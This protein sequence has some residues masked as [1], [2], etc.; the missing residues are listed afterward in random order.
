MR[1][2]VIFAMMPLLA[3]GA[4][5][6]L[7]VSVQ[8][9]VRV[10]DSDA[11]AIVLQIDSPRPAIESVSGTPYSRISLDNAMPPALEG[12]PD[13]PVYTGML[14]IPA[15]AIYS[16]SYQLFDPIR[17][18]DVKPMPVED[19]SKALQP[20]P[21]YYE[22]GEYPS[23]QVRA[24]SDA[25]I[26]DYRV[27][28]LQV[29]PFSWDPAQNTLTHY[30]SIRVSI[31]L[32]YPPADSGPQPY[33]TDSAAFRQLYEARILN[34]AKLRDPLSP[35]Q[36]PRVLI[37]HGD[38]NDPTFLAKLSEFATWKRQKGFEVSVAS[39]AVAGTSSTAIKSYIQAL[40]D[41]PNTRPD[42]IILIGDISGSFA[43][44]TCYETDSGYNGAGDY[45][46]TYLSGNDMLGDAFIGRMSAE[47]LSQLITLFSKVYTYEKNVNTTPP[48]SGWLNRMLII[49]DP[50][51]SGVSCVYTGHFI[52]NI[53]QQAH[54]EYEFIE[55]Y[56]D[57][58]VSTINSGI[59]QGVGFFAYRGYY[60]VSGWS[61]S[62]SLMNSVRLPHSVI[63]TCGTGPYEGESLSE[64]FIRMGTESV[65]AGAATCIGMSTSHTHTLFNNALTAGIM[66]G[67]MTHRMRTMGEALL[68]GRIYLHNVY[69]AALPDRVKAHAH[70][71]NL[72]GDPT[73]EA[74]VGI[75]T[76]LS[77]N[78]PASIPAGTS[79]LETVI[80]D[81]TGTPMQAVCVTA[82]SP[83]QGL[84]VAKTFTNSDGIA[85]L[86]L[87][88]T[89]EQSILITASGHD[90]KPLQSSISINPAGSLVYTAHQIM[91]NGSS[92]SSGNA[93]GIAG[94]GE[95]IALSVSLLNSTAS[96]LN[97]ISA[98]L[99]ID[100]PNL[101]ILVNSMPYPDMAAGF[102][103]SGSTPFLIHI[104]SGIAP[105]QEV[106]CVLTI[107]ASNSQSFQ[108]VFYLSVRNARLDVAE[109]LVTDGADGILDA[110]ETCALDLQVINSGACFVSNIQAELRSLDNLVVVT[111]S[112]S[113]FGN[114][115]AGSQ[116]IS[117]DGF[118]LR[119]KG[120][121]VPGM[122]VPMRLRLFNFN[123]FEQICLF[124]I[125]VGSVS[126]NTPLGPDAYGYL[127]Y[128]DTDTAFADCPVYD[129]VEIVPSLGGPG[130]L[131][132]GLAD[133]G[134]G[135]AEG[136]TASAHP[137][138]VL[139]LPF[140]FPYY[141]IVYNQITVCVNGFIAMGV[142]GNAD[143]RNV[144]LPGGQGACPMIA[145]FWDDL[146]LPNNAGVYYFYDTV[147][148]CF[149]IQYHNLKN[150]YDRASIA[151]FQVIFYDPL[152][153]HSGLGDGII[154]IQYKAF[155][156]VDVGGTGET[157]LHGN[158][159]T[160]GIKDHTNTRGLTYSFNNTYAPAAAP[161]SHE[162]AILITTI[163]VAH[164][165]PHLLVEDVIVHDANDSML[166]PG[167]SAEVGIMLHN[168]GL[169]N[170]VDV[171]ATLTSASP[172]ATVNQTL[173]EYG[174]IPSMASAVNRTAFVVCVADSCPD[175]TLLNL[176]CQV[177][178]ATGSSSFPVTL[179]V[180]RPVLAF[181]GV[182][183][184]DIA[185]N[186]NGMLEPGE[187][188]LLVLDFRN[189]TLVPAS[190][191]TVSIST[192][193]P[194]IALLDT[195]N[196]LAAIPPLATVQIPFRVS[197]DATGPVGT[198]VT[199]G[200]AYSIDQGIPQS[201]QVN[202]RIGSTG[203][204][205][206]FENGNGSFLPAPA[207]DAWQWGV[208]QSAGAHSGSHVWG[209]LLDQQYPNGV[210]WALTSPTVY[211]GSG[212]FLEFWHYYDTQGGCDGGNLQ[213]SVNSGPW[214]LITPIGGYPS[215]SVAA[216]DAP[217]FSGNSGW[218]KVYFDL[219]EYP[220]R[221]VSFRWT[222]ASDAA[223]QGMGWFIDDVCT[224]GLFG[225]TGLLTGQITISGADIE[226]SNVRISTQTGIMTT[227]DAASGFRLYLPVGTH[228]VTASA[229][230]YRSH[231]SSELV[232]GLQSAWLEQDF[233]LIEFKPV[234]DF[235]PS[236]NDHAVQLHWQP[237][238][239]PFFPI[240]GY[241]VE[242]RLN[243]GAFDNALLIT[244]TH[245]LELLSEPGRYQ[246]RVKAVYADGESL[247]SQTYSVEF[248]FSSNQDI[249]PNPLVTR[250]Y[251]NYPNP[252]NPSTR[253]TFDLAAP[254]KASLKVFNLRG[255]LVTTLCHRELGIG[256]HSFGWDGLDC[257]GRRVASGMYLYR[258]E[259]P[260]YTATRKMLLLK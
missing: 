47:N 169:G 145:P 74:W 200:L 255:Q 89:L 252:F 248:P 69:S 187:E 12:A 197:V 214:N 126:P 171:S 30:G 124:N 45:P 137:L 173:S 149:I 216:L 165:Q 231:A 70:W 116:T 43:V 112:L 23:E 25:W 60:G 100:D 61:P 29:C 253:V 176:H 246:Y 122:Q 39:T 96:T 144:M 229:P 1:I 58:F 76:V 15:N 220:N 73:L 2:R 21:V 240:T 190:N 151:T 72:M 157:P 36:S 243:A 33:S 156:N 142:T 163:P 127:I 189:T 125:P 79:T 85:V 44:P 101:Q 83:S 168:A 41:D 138:Q 92:G 117:T 219:A 31:R 204:Y 239:G 256:T 162:R 259:A 97:G 158:Y 98:N 141:G 14:A 13:L 205:H 114:I 94:A 203:L 232:I 226:P 242:R 192:T 188:A 184:N 52:H 18:M 146:Y 250:L 3:M 84:M 130:S 135:S 215:A 7:P 82:Y 80:T 17:V 155:N 208:S 179:M 235:I 120:W 175:A 66:T 241:R 91:D 225:F 88:S 22:G 257:T 139:D 27:L 108:S 93:D 54:P 16:I 110:G 67:V 143:F 133:S 63:L 87:P 8:S 35:H 209:T 105:S 194:H 150:K 40:Y 5:R 68:N 37:I 90:V 213:I 228:I 170:A 81:A 4:L 260:G 42:F 221:N 26:R 249:P 65:P 218:S 166:I 201:A 11:N 206:N 237:P 185:T 236:H 95:S 119:A 230:G 186:A 178:H 152:Y 244:D 227:M 53:A 34:Y 177:S 128:D 24:S 62:P 102:T 134:A 57:G 159:C 191:L 103:S 181:C 107:T 48:Y 258:L 56:N 160:I 77:M 207:T 195:I 147:Q 106:R 71:C 140:P 9:P 46:Y 49:G 251:A 113:W 167:E 172:Y 50:V 19:A 51:P 211:L 20:S 233:Q 223:T 28:P 193:N 247:P 59:N 121:L 55:N 115:P 64:D 234:R 132:S 212:N 182:T 75:P 217:G 224:Y 32:S 99:D 118:Q 164:P 109:I 153:H 6:A 180:R 174:D 222:F 131:I 86:E 123:G 210:T 254:G 148:H 199:L 196:G 136:E 111:D 129:W 154:K 10:L 38:Y 202:V 183:I 104:G 198:N 238:E 78:A 245:Y 161:M